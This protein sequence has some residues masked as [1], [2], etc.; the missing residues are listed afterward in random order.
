MV[1]SNTIVKVPDTDFARV[2]QATDGL[3]QVAAFP[4]NPSCELLKEHCF[5]K[6]PLIYPCN[7]HYRCSY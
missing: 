5:D 6:P 3:Q 1:R 7:E 2:L 4:E